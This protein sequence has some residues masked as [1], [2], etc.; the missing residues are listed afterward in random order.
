MSSLGSHTGTDGAVQSVRP[1]RWKVTA[2]NR[3]GAVD[4]LSLLPS[5][6]N[7]TALEWLWA[8]HW[9]G[10]FFFRCSSFCDSTK[11][12][13]VRVDPLWH[14]QC[15]VK[16]TRP[17]AWWSF[18]R[19]FARWSWKLCLR[20][21]CSVFRVKGNGV[22][23]YVPLLFTAYSKAEQSKLGQYF[24]QGFPTGAAPLSDR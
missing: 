8:E 5:C 18:V 14:Q 15:A 22:A 20:F 2:Q 23:P 17:T 7:K 9:W 4:L 10:L 11:V 19:V 6:M 1:S 13:C 21:L 16:S 24:K 12:N 3:H